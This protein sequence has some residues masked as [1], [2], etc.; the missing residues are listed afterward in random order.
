MKYPLCQ[1]TGFAV[2]FVEVGVGLRIEGGLLENA[3]GLGPKSLQE[4]ALALNKFGYI[5]DPDKWIGS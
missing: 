2:Y 1:D 4:I 5:D 3:I